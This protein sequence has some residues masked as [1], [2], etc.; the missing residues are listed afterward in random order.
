MKKR[1]SNIYLVTYI[2]SELE[3]IELPMTN[4]PV[5][6]IIEFVNHVYKFDDYDLYYSYLDYD[7]FVE[8]CY[9]TDKGYF[10]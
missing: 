5:E 3:I 2:S 10:I 9:A 4:M 7:H 6:G 8:L 1:K